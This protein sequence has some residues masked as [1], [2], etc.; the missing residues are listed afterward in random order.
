MQGGT[1]YSALYRLEMVL[2]GCCNDA[3]PMQALQAVLQQ[4]GFSIN[5]HTSISQVVQLLKGIKDAVS[6]RPKAWFLFTTKQPQFVPWM[7]TQ[8]LQWGEEPVL[9]R[10]LPLLVQLLPA[11]SSFKPGQK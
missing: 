2:E 1:H 4:A 5:K 9:E 7:V 11:P 3:L 6:S 10:V 8:A